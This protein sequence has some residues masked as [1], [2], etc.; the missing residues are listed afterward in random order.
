MSSSR[1]KKRPTKVSVDE[2]NALKS[3]ARQLEEESIA[4]STSIIP[5]K[6]ASTGQ[7]EAT[8]TPSNKELLININ[9]IDEDGEV[10]KTQANPSGGIS[11][12]FDRYSQHKG[13][14]F[15]LS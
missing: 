11:H 6:Q 13:T 4:T 5:L 3:R 15:L 10:L 8:P 7:R 9:F 14:P 1:N 2:I 12:L